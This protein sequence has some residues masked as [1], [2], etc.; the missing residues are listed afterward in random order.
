MAFGMKRQQLLKHLKR[1]GCELRQESANPS[2]YRNPVTGET[3]PIPRYIEKA[4]NRHGRY[5]V[6]SVSFCPKLDAMEL[7]LLV[8]EARRTRFC[9][10]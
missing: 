7:N 6:P 8:L 10:G 3:T 2:I 1:H 5:A 9:I 4:D